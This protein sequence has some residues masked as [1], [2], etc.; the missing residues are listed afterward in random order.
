M[1]VTALDRANAEDALL[2]IPKVFSHENEKEKAFQ[3]SLDKDIIDDLH[4]SSND[5]SVE[6]EGINIILSL[7]NA[8][9]INAPIV[10]NTGLNISFGLSPYYL[11]NQ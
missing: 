5:D 6:M 8:W 11:A 7:T 4:R 2:P 10:A 3:K 1:T 9:L